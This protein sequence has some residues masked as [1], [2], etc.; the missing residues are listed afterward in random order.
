[1][2]SEPLR[3][4]IR[5][6]GLSLQEIGRRAKVAPSQLSLFLKGERSLRLDTAERLASVLGAFRPDSPAFILVSVSPDRFRV[7][8][9]SGSI[10]DAPSAEYQFVTPPLRYSR[11]RDKLLIFYGM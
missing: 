11:A 8:R 6:S 7:A 9:R 1:M 2:L 3:Q 4:A 10:E 5:D